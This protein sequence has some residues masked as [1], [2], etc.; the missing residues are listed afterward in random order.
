MI[1]RIT[2]AISTLRSP[3]TDTSTNRTRNTDA[4]AFVDRSN[5]GGSK[6]SIKL[7]KDFMDA[8]KD[9]KTTCEN[10]IGGMR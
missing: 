6:F 7:D 4:E 5:T 10:P 1:K 8:P 2:C 3:M 9:S